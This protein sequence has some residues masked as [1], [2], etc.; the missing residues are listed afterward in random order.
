ML[1]PSLKGALPVTYF[2]RM[3]PLAGNFPRHRPNAFSKG[4]AR[5]TIVC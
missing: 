5:G 4:V 3:E 1:L 2:P